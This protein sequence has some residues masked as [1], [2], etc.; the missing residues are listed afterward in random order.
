M[1]NGLIICAMRKMRWAKC[2][3]YS[4]FGYFF[5][6]NAAPVLVFLYCATS[7]ATDIFHRS[8]PSPGVQGKAGMGSIL[9]VR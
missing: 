8:A 6:L 2:K 3:L 5:A 4:P 7:K 1:L 9:L